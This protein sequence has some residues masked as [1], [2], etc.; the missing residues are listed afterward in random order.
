LAIQV[1]LKA[2]LGLEREERVQRGLRAREL[3]VTGV[4]HDHRRFA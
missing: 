2:G 1:R 3:V 4:G